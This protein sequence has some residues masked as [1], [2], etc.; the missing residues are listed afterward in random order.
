[1]YLVQ[2]KEKNMKGDPFG[3]YAYEFME[4][5]KGVYAE[6]TWK[7]KNRRYRRMNTKF[8]E[9]GKAK[10]I[11]TRS[12]KNMNV[13]DIKAYIS[14]KKDTVATSDLV[15]DVA[16]LRKILEFCGNNA[17]NEC[18]AKYPGLKPT[19]KHTGPSPPVSDEDY[20]KILNGSRKV[21]PLNFNL[22]RGYAIVMLCL[23]TGTRNKE[24]RLAKL[25]DLNLDTWELDIIHVKGEDSY[26]KPRQSYVNPD[27]QDI[28]IMY[29]L[30]R[31]KYLM[32]NG[33]DSNALFPSKKG[34]FMSSNSIG[35]CKTLVEKNLGVKCDL[36]KCRRTFG[37]RVLDKG[38]D[39]ESTSKLMGHS[40]T[41]MTE[42]YYCRR[43]NK[44]ALK[45]VKKLWES[46]ATPPIEGLDE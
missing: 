12:P 36:R 21:D 43:N 37:Q 13:D 16:A 33:V 27:A 23:C 40:T 9:L 41:K 42:D 8:N 1:M 35:I 31:R 39:I 24:I 38:L 45:A 26:G 15:Q 11:S 34:E 46:P 19:V 7:T 20:L 29:L 5:M 17:L 10:L 32:D 18:F 28:V 25:E 3:K 6:E 22:V 2:R 30:A 14:S 44:L 4:A